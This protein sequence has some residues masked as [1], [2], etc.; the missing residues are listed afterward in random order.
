[1]IDFFSPVEVNKSD[2]NSSSLGGFVD[3]HTKSNWP[4]WE[5]KDLILLDISSNPKHLYN[6]NETSI[7]KIREAFY[8]LFPGN[9]NIN[10]AD[11]GSLS[12]GE[13]WQENKHL[14]EEVISFL[15]INKKDIIILGDSHSYTYPISKAISKIDEI[16]NCSIIDAKIDLDLENEITFENSENNN[17]ISS[18]LRDET[19]HLNDFHL[20][21]CQTY[22][23]PQSYF[24]FLKNMY[25]DCYK[26][27]EIKG[28]INKIEPELRTSHFT[29]IDLN[30]IENTYMPLQKHISPNGFNGLEICKLTRLSGLGQKNKI[31]GIF[32]YEIE[33]T[34]KKVGERLIAQM[35]WYY[36]E[37]KNESLLLKNILDKEEMIIFHIPN[38]LI[39]MKFYKQPETELWWVEIN[40]LDIEGQI[41]PCSYEDYQEAIKNKISSRIKKIIEKNKV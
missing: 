22:Y 14:I 28:N 21:G 39:K 41:F 25:V 31:I 10:I 12:L 15:L 24:H 19:L 3:I 33:N 18:I 11:L 8:T 4:D 29:S 20:L 23:H 5:T 13:N 2:F 34:G 37:G 38:N 17:F 6:E 1:M 36:I 9:W 32:D 27:G 26:L 7:T 30:A 16:V 40:D 35:I